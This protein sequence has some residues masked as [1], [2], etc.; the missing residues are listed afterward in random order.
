MILGYQLVSGGK[1]ERDLQKDP[2]ME[3]VYEQWFSMLEAGASFAAVAC[4]LN[5]SGVPL[6]HYS[7]NKRWDGTMVGRITRNPLLKGLRLHNRQQTR[8]VNATGRYRREL[9]DPSFVLR[10]DVPHL[11]FIEPSRFDRLI[12]QLDQRNR[13]YQRASSPEQDPSK[14]R[15]RRATRFPGQHLR[16]G[17]CGRLMVWGGHGITGRLMCNGVRQQRCWNGVTVSGPDVA[18]AVMDALYRTLEKHPEFDDLIGQVMKQQLTAQADRGWEER[19]RLE[20]RQQQLNRS[21]QKLLDAIESGETVSALSERLRQREAERAEVTERLKQLAELCVEPPPLPALCDLR[22][23]LRAEIEGLP[24]DDQALRLALYRL[25]PRL[26]VR[27]LRLI[28]RGHLVPEVFGTLRL[29]SMLDPHLPRGVDSTLAETVLRSVNIRLPVYEP[30]PAIKLIP[31]VREMRRGG[32]R[33]ATPG[34]IAR[35]LGSTPQMVQRA[36]KLLELTGDSPDPTYY[37]PLTEPPDDNHRHR[38]HQRPGYR[39][40]P[41]PGYPLSLEAL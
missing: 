25:A 12:N 6:P 31:R 3:P 30:H 2:A 24:L 27:P 14:G 11:A 32:G 35:R 5:E 29:A 40:E 1:Q 10:R 36:L 7:R 8:R 22:N 26:W 16:C 39:F 37:L 9:S 17:I 38:N 18:C 4:W 19:R 28:G 33:A 21:V 34:G 23:Q 41:L 20:D 13:I 15:P